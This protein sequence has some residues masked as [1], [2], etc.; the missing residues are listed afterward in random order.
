M[1]QVFKLSEP[2]FRDGLPL[3]R[4]LLPNLSNWSPRVQIYEPLGTIAIQTTTGNELI[5]DYQLL[6][7]SVDLQ[8]SHTLC[9][10][11]RCKQ[12]VPRYTGMGSIC[13]SQSPFSGTQLRE[14]PAA[15]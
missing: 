4:P 9:V 14:L 10:L 15:Q 5:G 6:Q 12:E 11:L 2:A 8:L 1:V 13:E 3:T 7:F